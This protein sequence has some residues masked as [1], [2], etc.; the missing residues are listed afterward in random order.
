MT[1]PDPGLDFSDNVWTLHK[2]YRAASVFHLLWW[3]A[4]AASRDE[5][6]AFMQTILV[7]QVDG[8][9]IFTATD[10]TRLHQFASTTPFVEDLKPGTYRIT[11]LTKST[12]QLE[13]TDATFPNYRNVIP[14][15]K[16]G[17]HQFNF[18][19]N[20]NLWE[21][22]TAV[23]CRH[24]ELANNYAVRADY[25]HALFG[26]PGSCHIHWSVRFGGDSTA[27]VFRNKL[28]SKNHRLLAVLSTM[29]TILNKAF[30]K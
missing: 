30:D 9:R 24:A 4:T 29:P 1:Q 18:T 28:R 3:V 14:Y 6:R 22:A 10:G 2:R 27:V 21:C 26:L 15:E 7:E 12:L 19:F 8:E 17:D 23:V 20:R 11:K 25:V 16:L 5:T 13:R